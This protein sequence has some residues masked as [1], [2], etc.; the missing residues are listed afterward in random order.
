MSRYVSSDKINQMKGVSIVVLSSSPM[1]TVLMAIIDNFALTDRCIKSLF[2]FTE[3]PFVLLLGDN[4]TGTDG[5]ANFSEWRH[6]PNTH[7]IQSDA[8]IQHGEMIDILLTRVKTSYFVLMDSDT[9]ILSK[10]WL[11]EMIQGFEE[12]PLVMQV[13]ADF[14]NH[15]ENYL[16]PMDNQVVRYHERFGPWLLMYRSEV[17]E[18]CQGTSFVFYKEWVEQNG[19]AKYSYW[20]TGGRIHF[21]LKEKGYYYRIRPNNFR[22]NYLHYGRMKWR[23]NPNG[24]A[25]S[26][27]AFFR[28]LIRRRFGSLAVNSYLYKIAR[29]I[30]LFS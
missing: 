10:N 27:I 7:V 23:E 19:E 3:E 29:K 2:R 5:K 21:A 1:V 6:L 18:I 12:D 8:R 26:M 4:G 25:F 30:G 9:E 13:G 15:R 16:A 24:V 28:R 20:D 22:R 17:K 11:R 14:I